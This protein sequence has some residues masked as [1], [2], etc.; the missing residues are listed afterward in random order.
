MDSYT[1]NSMCTVYYKYPYVK[2]N[3]FVP[4][5]RKLSKMI[6]IDSINIGMKNTDRMFQNIERLTY[7]FTYSDGLYSKGY[8]TY[9]M[10]FC[11]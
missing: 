10:S 6:I 11:P 5:C 7:R 8:D 1:C 9:C 2:V 3:F 4:D